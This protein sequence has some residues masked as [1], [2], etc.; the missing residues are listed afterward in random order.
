MIEQRPVVYLVDDD[1]LVRHSLEALVASAGLRT[2]SFAS[3]RE[4]I[5]ASLS[6]SPSCLVLDVHLPDFNG[7]ELQRE[8]VARD[9]YTP[10]IFIT[11]HG[12]IPTTVRA[13]KEG[14]IEFLTKPVR[15]RDLLEA[16]HR[17]LTLDQEL[18]Q[19]RAELRDLR[20]RFT[21]L[22]PR[23][24]QVLNLLIAGYLNKEIAERLGTTEVTVKTH[25]AHLMEK[26]RAESPAHL[27]HLFERLNAASRNGRPPGG[28][29]E[30][31]ECV[32]SPNKAGW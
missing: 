31:L 18:Q 25:R 6:D 19:T 29:R 28:R 11:G 3:A 9:V 16:V 4:F 20:E 32:E 15:G 17:G 7:L 2:R 30:G 22:T 12:D 5:Q 8:L 27:A 13:M 14:A 26:T 10:I 23:E 21:T 1:D 24:T